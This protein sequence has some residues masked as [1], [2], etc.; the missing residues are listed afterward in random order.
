[1][2][3]G[4][5]RVR[6]GRGG[7]PIAAAFERTG[8]PPDEAEARATLVVS[9]LRGLCQDLLVTDDGERVEAA[10]TRLLDAAAS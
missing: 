6:R 4:G 7:S 1:M 3:G 2:G 9:G 8:F 10:A 5:G